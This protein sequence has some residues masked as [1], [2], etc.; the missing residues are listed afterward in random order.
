MHAPSP[1]SQL[2]GSSTSSPTLRV[3]SK[4]PHTR[5][6]TIEPERRRGK[7]KQQSLQVDL[8]MDFIIW[9]GLIL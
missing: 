8:E 7:A 4:A 6:F 1:D 5:Y 9:C 2:G 3:W